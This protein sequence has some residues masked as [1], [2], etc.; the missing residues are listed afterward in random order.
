MSEKQDLTSDDIKHISIARKAALHSDCRHEYMPSTSEE[1]EQW[2]PH[3][4]VLDAMGEAVA[5]SRAEATVGMNRCDQCGNVTH[6][7]M[8]VA[9]PD[10]VNRWF[11]GKLAAER[12][13][14]RELRCRIARLKTGNFIYMALATLGWTVVVL[15]AYFMK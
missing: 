6:L 13:E 4:W 12:K 14:I 11:L 2:F 3:R 1:A 7:M 5:V 9:Q 15:Q 10:N 8:E